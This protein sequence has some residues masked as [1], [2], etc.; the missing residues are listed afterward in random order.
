MTQCLEKAVATMYW[1]ATTRHSFIPHVTQSRWRWWQCLCAC[2]PEYACRRLAYT[3][4]RRRWWGVDPFCWLRAFPLRGVCTWMPGICSLSRSKFSMCAGIA[5]D[6]HSALCTTSWCLSPWF[7]H[8]LAFLE[9]PRSTSSHKV[10]QIVSVIS[11][12]FRF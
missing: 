8:V 10:R 11:T 5:D 4:C 2:R 6:A 7:C 9:R 3:A 12:L 1:V